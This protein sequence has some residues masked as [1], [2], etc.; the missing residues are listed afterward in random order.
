MSMS[1]LCKATE[2]LGEQDSPT[3][4]CF[5]VVQ[6]PKTRRAGT[7]GNLMDEARGSGLVTDSW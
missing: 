4:Y 1:V 6:E 7:Q 5:Q 2:F 3:K